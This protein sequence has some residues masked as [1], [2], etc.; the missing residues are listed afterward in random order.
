[1]LR[2]LEQLGRDESG[3]Q[4]L[5]ERLPAVPVEQPLLRQPQGELE[6]FLVQQRRP[7]LETVGHRG[8]IDLGQEAVREIRVYI[9][10]LHPAQRRAVAIPVQLRQ[11]RAHRVAVVVPLAQQIS[12]VEPTHFLISHAGAQRREALWLVQCES[13]EA[14]LDP[15]RPRRPPAR[16]RGA[17]PQRRLRRH[18]PPA[19][20]PERHPIPIVSGEAF[21]AAVSR[22]HHRDVLPRLLRQHPDGERRGIA[23]RLRRM[24]HQGGEEVDQLRA[25]GEGVMPGPEVF[26]N[27]LRVPALVERGLGEAERERRG[28]AGALA[29]RDRRHQARID[30]A[31]QE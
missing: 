6:H 14:A 25:S 19:R 9:H 29:G 23:K 27:A 2:S 22:E 8:D 21:I 1:M 4:G 26:G 5:E 3:Q 15:L 16:H 7:R 11:P 13:A 24:P 18:A 20:E 30:A 31:A 17:E 28:L 10:Q 12:R